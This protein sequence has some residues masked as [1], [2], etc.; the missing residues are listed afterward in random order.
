MEKSFVGKFV[1]IHFFN[2]LFNIVRDPGKK[3]QRIRI[4]QHIARGCEQAGKNHRYLKAM[5]ALVC[6]L[7]IVRMI[8]MNHVRE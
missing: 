8:F 6:I 7:I 5:S 1:V 3:S 4:H 2:N